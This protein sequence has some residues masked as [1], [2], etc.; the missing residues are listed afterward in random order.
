MVFS[1]L[2][3]VSASFSQVSFT[4]INTPYVQN[5]DSLANTGT[6]TWTDNSTIT[7]WYSTRIQYVAGNGSS[8]T[9]AFY[10]YG[11]IS[12]T[13]RCLGSLASGSTGIINYGVRIRN[14][15]GQPIG[16][17]DI[18]YTGEQ[19]RNAGIP[20]PQQLTIGYLQATTVT[21]LI[22]PGYIAM[23]SLDFIM[24]IFGGTAGNLDG[25]DPANRRTINGTFVV[26]V[27]VG[28]EIMIRWQDIDNLNIDH[29]IG[30][31]DLTLTPRLAPTAANVF[32]MG[33]VI[34]ADG[35][36]ISGARL[37]IH[38]GDLVQPLGSLTNSFGYFRFVDLRA[39]ETYFLTINSK[40]NV[41]EIPT[42]A[43]TP[44]SD[45]SDLVIIASP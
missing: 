40:G 14:D 9:G 32:V 18:Q 5:F 17:I 25:N 33:R 15:T 30:I 43:I 6:T 23:N 26:S 28:E 27:P 21:S 1:L 22:I 44:K 42:L 29:G 24:P 37:S 38:G 8:N 31:D 20:T 36:S 19:W 4:T 3:L 41:F 12:S 39:G 34:T 35:R 7:G 2:L 11:T 16:A 10:S 45:I 13:D